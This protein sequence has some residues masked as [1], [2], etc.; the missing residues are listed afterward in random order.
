MVV[1]VW[2]RGQPIVV[3]A[4]LTQ[5]NRNYKLIHAPMPSTQSLRYVVPVGVVWDIQG[6][7]VELNAAGS[8]YAPRRIRVEQSRLDGETLYTLC[9]VTSIIVD[10]YN[11]LYMSCGPMI[12]YGDSGPGEHNAF[13]GDSRY[14]SMRSIVGTLYSGDVILIDWDAVP[15][16]GGRVSIIYYESAYQGR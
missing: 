7:Y 5:L 16:D 8:T 13:S 3:D 15:S 1:P 4:N 14:I 12:S 2:I 10:R 11:E 9:R 6:I